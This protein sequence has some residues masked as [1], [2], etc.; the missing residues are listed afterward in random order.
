M[1][2][3]STM[4]GKLMPPLHNHLLCVFLV[5][6]SLSAPTPVSSLSLARLGGAGGLWFAPHAA[7]AG[8]VGRAAHG[9]SA[10]VACEVGGSGMRGGGG[11][12]A[13]QV[14]EE[15]SPSSCVAMNFRDLCDAGGHL[16]AGK[17][18]RTA[19]LQAAY[20]P[21]GVSRMLCE[22]HQIGCVLDLRSED[23]MKSDLPVSQQ[24]T[25]RF[26]RGEEWRPLLEVDAKGD[27][28]SVR[29]IVPLMERGPIA[30]GLFGGLNLVDKAKM[31]WFGLV[32]SAKQQDMFIS[33]MNEG[34]LLGLSILIVDE[35][36]QEVDFALKV[37]ARHASRGVPVAFQCRLGKDRTGLVAAL[38]LLCLGA[39]EEQVVEDYVKS[40][41]TD[42]IALGAVQVM[43]PR[44]N[45]DPLYRTP[46]C[47]SHLIPT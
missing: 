22:T 6:L 27:S 46:L 35:C 45:L 40:D 31:A 24:A 13:Q 11:E 23:E 14:L 29:Y 43:S 9:R 18:F 16:K 33:K 5:L 26:K 42:G 3:I 34:G 12:V 38:V 32:D 19:C 30:K 28:E 17:V 41:G 4:A 21:E 8:R 7:P 39:S 25:I 1:A 36:H 10:T 47:A 20:A 44:S 15:P 2:S 37:I